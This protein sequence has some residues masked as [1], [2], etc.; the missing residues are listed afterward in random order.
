MNAPECAILEV[1][2]RNL[3]GLPTPLLQWEGDTTPR[4][5]GTYG[6]AIHEPLAFDGPFV[7]I[8]ELSLYIVMQC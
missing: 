5:I 2:F 3:L 6:I 1:K 4:P 7:A 8:L